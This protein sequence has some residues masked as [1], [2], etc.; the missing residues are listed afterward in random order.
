MFNQKLVETYPKFGAYL[1]V[2]K[3]EV[4]IVLSF[5]EGGTMTYWADQG[6]FASQIGN[7]RSVWIAGITQYVRE[8]FHASPNVYKELTG[9]TIEETVDKVIASL[10]GKDVQSMTMSSVS[11]NYTGDRLILGNNMGQFTVK[12]TDTE[13]RMTSYTGVHQNASLEKIMVNTVFYK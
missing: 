12:V 5:T 10:Q 11:Y 8:K 4:T 3:F 13:L 6:T 9:T 2:D 7:Y 1:F